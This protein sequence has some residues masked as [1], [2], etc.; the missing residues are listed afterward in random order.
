MIATNHLKIYLH[1]PIA[2]DELPQEPPPSIDADNEKDPDDNSHFDAA[3]DDND[4]DF[5]AHT[6]Y[7]LEA[8]RKGPPADFHNVECCLAT[9]DTLTCIGLWIPFCKQEFR[10]CLWQAR[11]TPSIGKPTHPGAQCHQ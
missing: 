8:A 6:Y 5:L 9:C 2:P 10:R 3:D 11:G 1:I 4:D 7:E